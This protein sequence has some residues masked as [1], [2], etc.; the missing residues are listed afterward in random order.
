MKRFNDVR[1]LLDNY[2]TGIN[3]YEILTPDEERAVARN[4]A[5]GCAKARDVMLN[6]NLRLVV[7]I[8]VKFHPRGMDLMDLIQEGNRGLMRAIDKFN[9]ERENKFSTYA[10]FWIRQAILLS[11]SNDSRNVRV[12]PQIHQRIR[13]IRKAESKLLQ[14]KGQTPTV[15]EICEEA[16]VSLRQFEQAGQFGLAETSI[17]ENRDATT[18]G[19]HEIIEEKLKNEE[20]LS[21]VQTLPKREQEIIRKRFCLDLLRKRTLDELGQKFGLSKERIRILEKETLE[22]LS[23]IRKIQKLKDYVC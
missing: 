14:Q 21:V 15:Q 23:R 18:T 4:V 13:R 7:S 19:P 17:E 8:A 2:L 9:L 10:T 22:T 16:K 11:L 5:K 20:L 6:H 1:N 12:P 3:Q